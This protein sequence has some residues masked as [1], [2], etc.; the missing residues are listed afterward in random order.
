MCNN[1]KQNKYTTTDVP[2]RIRRSVV[3]IPIPQT[4]V[5]PIVEITTHMS[6]PSKTGSE[7]S[8]KHTSNPFACYYTKFIKLKLIYTKEVKNEKNK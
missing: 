1:K 2:I 5:S 4:I 3:Q 7:S 6:N 8:A